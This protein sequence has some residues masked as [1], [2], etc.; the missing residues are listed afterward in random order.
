MI[1]RSL[2]LGAFASLSCAFGAGAA[3]WGGYYIGL[4][5]G[6]GWSESDTTRTITNNAYFAPANLTAVEAS[7]AM[8]LEEETFAGGAQVGVN[9]PLS[10][11]LLLGA[12]FD[13]LG[14]GNDTSAA[15]NNVPYPVGVGINYSVSSSVEQ[16]WL[17][18]ARLRIGFTAGWFMAYATGGYA[19]GET[20]F[21]QTFTDNAGPI[22][23]QTVE[24]S[25][26]R[27][28]HSIGGGIEVM[29]ESGASLK[30]EYLRYDLGEIS[31]SGPIAIGGTT[32]NGVADVTN[33]VWRVGFN[34]K[35]D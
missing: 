4:N 22:A 31:A 27:S 10:E 35:M 30:F 13:A 21:A 29:I 18:S 19:G 1:V 34:F 23:L 26:F 11:H 32:S 3:D 17:A 15:A 33:D 20:K 2:A 6:Q 12:E 5:A 28:G 9:W 16:T 25:E 24:N 8:L 14:Y 7:S